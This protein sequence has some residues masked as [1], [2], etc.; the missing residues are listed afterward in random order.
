[1]IM[2]P[3]QVDTKNFGIE[4]ALPENLSETFF[5][6]NK[7]KNNKSQKGLKRF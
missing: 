1:M 4:T 5:K 6:D 3:E 7:M 2:T